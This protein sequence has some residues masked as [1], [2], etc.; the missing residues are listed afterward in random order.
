MEIRTDIPLPAHAAR[1]TNGMRPRYPFAEL[2]VGASFAVPADQG[3]AM[4]AAAR[5]WKHRHKG[6]DFTASKD[7]DHLRLWR[8]A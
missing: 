5:T 3:D 2:T 6:W 4:R 8:T 1:R 7:G